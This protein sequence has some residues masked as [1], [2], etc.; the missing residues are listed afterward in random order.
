MIYSSQA[1]DSAGDWG[2]D[3]QV[4]DLKNYII[5]DPNEEM[6]LLDIWSVKIRVDPMFRD[7]KRPNKFALKLLPGVKSHQQ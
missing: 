3:P 1:W 4:S 7:I 6:T 5:M 2:E